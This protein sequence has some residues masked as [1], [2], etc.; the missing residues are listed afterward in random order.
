MVDL[1]TIGD[2]TH[3]ALH[4]AFS[5]KFS[6]F[7]YQNNPFLSIAQ[8]AFPDD[9]FAHLHNLGFGAGA[10]SQSASNRHQQSL[11]YEVTA[12]M[13]AVGEDIGEQTGFESITTGGSA[14]IR[15]EK[16]KYGFVSSSG[17]LKGEQ[18]LF[19][20]AMYRHMTDGPAIQTD[21][22]MF[23]RGRKI[24]ST[25]GMGVTG[26]EFETRLRFKC[27][28][29]YTAK[30]NIVIYDKTNFDDMYNYRHLAVAYVRGA[31][32]ISSVNRGRNSLG[33]RI[34]TIVDP[35]VMEILAANSATAFQG[36]AAQFAAKGIGP[37]LGQRGP[38][39]LLDVMTVNSNTYVK[40]NNAIRHIA[41]TA[42]ALT[43]LTIAA[44]P[45]DGAGT[46]QLT[47]TA[48]S[49]QYT[50]KKGDIIVVTGKKFL[51]RIQ[52]R[53]TSDISNAKYSSVDLC[54]IAQEDATSTGT[55]TKTVT[56]KI[57]PTLYDN[58][59]VKLADLD[60]A[61]AVTVIPT[62]RKMCIM[63]SGVMHSDIFSPMKTANIKSLHF[64][65]VFS[66]YQD[67]VGPKVSR[68]FGLFMDS[69]EGTPT[70]EFIEN[71]SLRAYNTNFM[72]EFQSAQIILPDTDPSDVDMLP[73]QY[74]DILSP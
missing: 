54:L 32:G 37:L 11:E 44:K 20:D 67:V 69:V 60:A 38:L 15:S 64:S 27:E 29:D 57:S 22:E 23:A 17:A 30:C 34:Y 68:A 42:S 71:Y 36:S 31:I 66:G 55:T 59:N 73:R 6:G 48:A 5:D 3:L 16:G 61:V 56:V 1:T 46:I 51:T 2:R 40:Y 52:R 58:E 33:G 39:S 4:A 9:M 43:D 47:S 24:L 18:K 14:T 10:G 74:V 70:N 41:G 63:D 50:I 26:N 21:S 13:P 12:I 28:R 53:T 25:F 62:H 19:F 65:N 49:A 45:A 72:H 35:F 7:I 8:S